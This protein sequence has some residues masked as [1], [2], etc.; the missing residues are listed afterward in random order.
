MAHDP[1]NHAPFPTGSAVQRT[2]RALAAIE[3]AGDEGRRI[4]TR[5]YARAALQAA[6]A[7]DERAASGITLGPLDGRIVSIK[8]LLDV[9]GEPTTAGSAALRNA[10]PAA[11]DAVVV[12]R[13]RAAGCVLIGKT[14][15]TE[16]AFSGIGL[17]PHFG[18]PGNAHDAARIPGGSSSGAGVSVARG[19]AEIAIGTD[20]GGS[21]R[22]PAAF[23]GIAGFKPTQARVSRDGALALSYTLDT[24]GPLAASVHDCAR[25]DA[26]LSGQPWQPLPVRDVAGLRIGVP[27]GWLLREADTAVLDAFEAALRRLSGAGARLTDL[28]LD[29]WM[30]APALLQQNGSIAAAEAAHVHR[31]VLA[32]APQQLD[33]RVLARIVP[34]QSV[35]APHYIG[36]LRE[37]TRLQVAFDAQLEATGVDLLALPTVP[38]APPCIAELE[39]DDAAFMRANALV[40]RNPSVFNF[41]DLP[42][43]SLPFGQAAGLPFGLMLVAP[44]GRDHEL[45]AL[46]AAIKALGTDA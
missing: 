27:R 15:M 2:E 41:Y 33:P 28:A 44:R 8:D 16:F 39:R 29:E 36:V 34:G 24:I 17:N 14:N 23:A 32:R 31:E 1:S 19:M 46:A 40:L 10:P 38:I 26:V 30:K 9:A 6:R 25:A 5:V 42:A 43:L 22:I 13:L 7:A 37:R 20:T 18:T 12:Q 4:F 45:L 11:Q 21:V 3:A 35:P